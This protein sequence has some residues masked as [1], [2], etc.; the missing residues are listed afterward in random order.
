MSEQGP[1]LDVLVDFPDDCGQGEYTRETVDQLMA[2]VRQMG[3]ARVYWNYYGNADEEMFFWDVP[4]DK[5]TRNRT[6]TYR[7]LNGSLGVAV[8]AA[9]RH[10][11]QFF[12]I[13]KP[14]ETGI[15]SMFHEGT[16]EERTY[17]RVP[18]LGG[19][20]YWVT[21]FVHENP[22]KRIRRR[23]H[24][25]PPDVGTRRVCSIKLYKVDHEP[26]RIGAE[27][28][29]IWTNSVNCRY[30]KRDVPLDLSQSVEPAP[31]DVEDFEGRILA[32]Q[33]SASRVLTL[34]GLD[35]ADKYIAIT[36]N[37]RDGPA[38]FGNTSR[39]MLRVYDAGGEEIPVSLGTPS[40]IFGSR[41][42]MKTVGVDFDTGLAR[43]VQHL[44]SPGMFLAFV[45]GKN[46]YLGGALCESEPAV[47]EFLLRQVDECLAAGAD[48]VDFRIENHS[49]CTDN[50]FAYGFNDVILD[51]YAAKYG[52]I[53]GEKDVDLRKL[54]DVRGDFYDSFVAETARRVRA[55]GKR[56]AHHINV[57][58]LRPDPR[59]RRREAYPWNIRFHWRAWLERGLLDEVTLRTYQYY[60]SFVLKDPFSEE[61][62]RRATDR[63][64]PINYVRYVH[65]H[66]DP[67]RLDKPDEYTEEMREIVNDGRC[68]RL[69]VYETANLFAPDGTGR[70][71]ARNEWPEK[72]RTCASALGM[73]AR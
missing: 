6:A 44:D 40:G 14:Y 32:R 20:M 71:A 1:R 54:S 41:S 67:K 69:T 25:V 28:L 12:A 21:R 22:S 15:A 63:G 26:T 46:E 8:E 58:Y 17:G 13:I 39:C 50:A 7:A 45:R 61:V 53:G 37:F 24:Y 68:R 31:C 19:S 72:I 51:A 30:V 47:R 11:M 49:T 2:R 36:T 73:T 60:P 10:G 29:E 9:H 5:A 52:A 66:H 64:L 16:E 23:T 65:P 59:A 43:F 18:R 42:D 57:E 33:G 38:D 35:L 56:M 4:D 48:G 34:A 55:A 62:M 27:N 70:L 3:A